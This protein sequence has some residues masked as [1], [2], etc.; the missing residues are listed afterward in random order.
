[1]LMISFKL[2]KIL[3][4][5]LPS[6]FVC[7][8]PSKNDLIKLSYKKLNDLY[9]ENEN[10]PTKQI[11][12]TNAYMAKANQE[13]NNIRKAKANYQIALLYYKSDK[14]KAISYLDSVI[15]YSKNSGDKFFPAAAHCEK[16]AFLKL[17]FKFK[18]AMDNYKA[19]EKIALETNIDYYYVVRDYIGITKSEDLGEYN[20]ALE[21]YKECY[22]YYKTKDYRTDKY[23]NDFQNIIFGIADCYKSLQNTDSTTYYNKLGFRESTIT[24]NTTLQHIFTLNEGANEISKKNYSAALDSI[25]KALPHIIKQNDFGNIMAAYFYLGKAYDGMGKSETAVTNYIKVDSIYNKTKDISIEFIDGYPYLISYYKKKGDKENQ[26]MYISKYMSIDSTLQKNYKSLDKLIRNEYDI[27]HIISDK[28]N[29][30]ETLQ[31]EKL[32]SYWGIAGLTLGILIISVISFYQFEYKKRYRSR[33]EKIMLETKSKELE[34][35]NNN[36]TKNQKEIINT[37]EDIGIGEEMIKYILKKL[38]SFE[39]EKAFL[40]SGITIQ[41]VSVSFET[42]SKYLSKVINTYL[43]KT[44][45]QYINDLRIDHALH[46][47]TNNSKLRKYTIQALAIEFGFNNAESFSSAFH[48]KSGIKPAYFIKQLENPL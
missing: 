43:N 23:A 11:L 21:I 20:E 45:I 32:K 16:A 8:Q 34:I 40:S 19:A 29:L 42:N 15:K 9:F 17:Q 14:N 38:D 46:S 37:N 41:S 10:N 26:L 13:N 33:F 2:L 44:F 24:K 35:T 12:Y 18:E 48:K 36:K 30:I 1:M 28:E 31:K 3:F 25:T 5:L 7:A 47:L 6:L 27:P 39:K 4:F 22:T